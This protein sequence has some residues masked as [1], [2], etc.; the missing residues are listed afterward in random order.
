MKEGKEES[1]AQIA[2]APAAGNAEI[3]PQTE[4]NREPPARTQPAQAE[5]AAPIPADGSPEPAESPAPVSADKPRKSKGKLVLAVCGVA[6]VVVAVAGL[7]VPRISN[8]KS[9]AQAG[10]STS[11][12]AEGADY[13]IELPAE[14]TRESADEPLSQEELLYQGVEEYCRDLASE[15]EYK[16]AVAYLMEFTSLDYHDPRFGSL[17]EEYRQRYVDDVLRIAEAYA[18]DH[19][20]RKAIELLDDSSEFYDSWEFYDAAVQYRQDFGIYNTSLLAA[21]KYNTILLRDDGTVLVCGDGTYNELYA[22]NWSGMVA[23]SAGDRHLVGLKA[24][25]TV[26]AVGDNTSTQRDVGSWSNII[27]IS[28][29]DVHTVG[30]RADGTLVAT[31][32][33][34]YNQTD[35]ST[36]MSNCGTKRIVSV[37]AGYVHTLALMED[38]TVAAVGKNVEGECNVYGWTDIVAIYAG[39]KFSAGLRS[40]GTVVATGLNVDKWNLDSWTDIVNLAAG[41]YY[42]VGLKADGTVVAAGTNDA[43]YSEQGQMN[44]RGWENVIFISAGNDHT[45]AV[46]ADG[47]VLCVGSNKYGQ[48]DCQGVMLTLD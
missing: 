12:M 14:I 38:G 47:T 40:D 35:M 31:G 15:G 26:V 6:V 18:A 23:V 1:V 32:T 27:A 36:L 19:S 4:G 11:D 37:A 29:G 34:Q 2:Q 41:D 16:A 3:R 7:V 44:V 42:L 30:L 17:L 48:C 33:N 39:T 28:A 45:V 46:T 10:E 21:G 22:R 13:A 25:G 8:G 5:Q 24:D 43:N 20:Y 9:T